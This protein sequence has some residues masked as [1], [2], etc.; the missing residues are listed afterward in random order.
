M[1][2]DDM[3]SLVP[4]DVYENLSGEKR[5]HEKYSPKIQMLRRHT[6]PQLLRKNETESGDMY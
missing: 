2:R 4:N 1:D 5:P 3:L 6:P